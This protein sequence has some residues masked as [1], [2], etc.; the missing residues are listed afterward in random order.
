MWSRLSALSQRFGPKR[1]S[2]I[3]EY[4]D[5]TYKFKS[6]ARVLDVSPSDDEVRIAVDRTIFHPQ[7]GGQ[8]SDSGTI[9]TCDG[10]EFTVDSLSID[11]ET[12]TIWHIGKFANDA[13]T[14]AKGDEVTLAIDGARR[15]L[16]AM[17][18]SA[19][20]ILDIVMAGIRPDLAPSKG[21]HFPGN[22]WV[23]YIGKVDAGD[24]P[25]VV[26]RLQSGIDDLIA[27]SIPT[28]VVVQDDGK[29]TIQFG[30]HAPVG[31]GGTHVS[32]TSDF[33][34]HRIVIDKIQAVKGGARVKYSLRDEARRES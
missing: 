5:D 25:D 20:H 23:E 28:T 16:H 9:T 29:R 17:L 31:C 27:S 10:R 13:G 34:P 30:S 33:G 18:H 11:R 6:H 2:T 24:R 32:A 4:F 21:C 1:M 8:P 15:R 12:D 14:L 19:G 26:R 7:G 22:A 3:R